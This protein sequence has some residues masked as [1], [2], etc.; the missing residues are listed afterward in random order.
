MGIEKASRKLLIAVLT[1]FFTVFLV[2][3]I[4]FF[5]TAGSFSYTNGWIYL[6]T[7]LITLLVG[8]VALYRKDKALLKKR[9][10]TSEKDPK[11]KVFVVLS[12]ILVTAI[13]G[14]PGFD[15]RYEWSNVPIYIVVF[16]EIILLTGYYLNLKVMLI[17]SYASRVVEI[18][19]GQKLIDTGLYSLVRHPMYMALILIYI[20]TCF[21]LGSYIA[22]LPCGVMIIV[23]GFRAIN[24]EKMLTEGLEGY[25]EY[26]KKVKYRMIPYVW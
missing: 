14:I 17:N 2:L 7:I 16:G 23:L 3:M 5:S 22:L 11:Q 10:K 1:K 4:L 26:M 24:E 25:K 9:I 12:V 8:L 20:G 15:Y 13:Y 18:Q 19:E 6:G 21:I